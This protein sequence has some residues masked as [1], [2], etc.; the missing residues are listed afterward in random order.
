MFMKKTLFTLLACLTLGS[1]LMAQDTADRRFVLKV[2]PLSIFLLTG[3][4]QFEAAVSDKISVQLGAYYTGISVGGGNASGSG[5]V[6]YRLLSLTPEM[7][8]YVLNGESAPKGLYV[9]PFARI[10]TGYLQANGNVQDPDTQTDVAAEIRADVLAI[11]GGA[12]IGYQLV[13]PGGFVF[14]AFVG[15]QFSVANV[16]LSA[17]CQGCDGNESIPTIGRTLGGPGLRLGL[18][19][20]YAF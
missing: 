6:A 17:D 9:A 20:G 7:R 13:T 10:R 3:N 19:L 5:R 4:V 14:D 11:G 16:N 12:T 8:Y 15:P 2:N 18:A 1:T